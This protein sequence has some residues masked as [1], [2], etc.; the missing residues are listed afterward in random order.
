MHGDVQRRVVAVAGGDVGGILPQTKQGHQLR[1]LKPN[2]SER[3]SRIRIL[4]HVA[5]GVYA[6]ASQSMHLDHAHVRARVRQLEIVNVF[7]R[8]H[9]QEARDGL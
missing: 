3:H 6:D 9:E 4:D 2:T 7:A 5:V 1:V 8:D